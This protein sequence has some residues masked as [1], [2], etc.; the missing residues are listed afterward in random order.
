M[1]HAYVVRGA[2]GDTAEVKAETLEILFKL[3][4]IKFDRTNCNYVDSVLT[5]YF[6]VCEA[7]PVQS[8]FYKCIYGPHTVRRAGMDWEDEKGL[9]GCPNLNGGMHIADLDHPV[10]SLLQGSVGG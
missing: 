8:E 10:D 3:K 4:A 7:R 2:K 5:H 9:R 6:D 1:N